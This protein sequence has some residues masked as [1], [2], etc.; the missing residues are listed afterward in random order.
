M[1]KTTR[2]EQH[3]NAYAD[4]VRLIRSLTPEQFLEPAGGW[5]PRDVVAHLIGWNYNI[6]MGCEDI[7]AGRVPFYHQD[8]LNDYRT[9][10]AEFTALYDSTDSGNLLSQL[11]EASAALRGY[12]DGTSPEDWE[13]DFGPQHYR[14]GPATIDRCAESITRE[15]E[16]HGKEIA[17]RILSDAPSSDVEHAK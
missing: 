12:F 6:R 3:D 14:G 8:A 1:D 17:H 7:R 9:L 16:E 10:N 15:Y 13:R 5:A 4:F 2:L 11:Q